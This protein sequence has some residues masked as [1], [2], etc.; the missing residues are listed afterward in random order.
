M[1]EQTQT[2]IR[3][4][5]KTFG[6]QTDQAIAAHLEANPTVEKL[7]LRLVLED[8]TDYGDAPPIVP[9]TVVVEGEVDQPNE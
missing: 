3:K 4:L 9:L 1:S 2:N 7:H 8:L 6:V 5:L